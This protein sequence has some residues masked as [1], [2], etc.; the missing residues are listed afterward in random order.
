MTTE[1][2]PAATPAPTARVY[3][4]AEYVALQAKL[5]AANGEAAG[6]RV[7]RDQHKTVAEL[8]AAEV[9]AAAAKLAEVSTVAEARILRAELKAAAVS[10]GAADAGDVLALIDRDAVKRDAKGEPVN[11]AELVAELKAA[12]PYLFTK[13]AE[14]ATSSSSTEKKPD[15]KA[16]AAKMAR[17]MTDEEYKAQKAELTRRR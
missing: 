17:D 13:P 15:P 7:D 11:L 12:K 2:P 9:S 8:R 3:T 4:E 14:P 5:T 1:A 16:P 6:Y 10:A